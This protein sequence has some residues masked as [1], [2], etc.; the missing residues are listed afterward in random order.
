V[1]THCYQAFDNAELDN[2]SV[3]ANLFAPRYLMRLEQ[4]VH[5]LSR[6]IYLGPMVNI[7]GL[8]PRFLNP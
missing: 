7:G 4:G 3:F 1:F 6:F 5:W 2:I 8:N